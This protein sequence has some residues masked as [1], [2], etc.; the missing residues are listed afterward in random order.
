MTSTEHLS[1]I[2]DSLYLLLAQETE[3]R[4][5]QAALASSD[6]K[7]IRKRRAKSTAERI[8]LLEQR[9]AQETQRHSD[10]KAAIAQARR[11]GSTKVAAAGLEVANWRGR[12]PR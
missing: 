5:S 9:L 8:Y 12:L 3:E 1:Q 6:I 4:E 7:V 2:I 11:Q 10:R